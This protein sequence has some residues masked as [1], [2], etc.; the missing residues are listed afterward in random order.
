MQHWREGLNASEYFQNIQNIVLAADGVLWV[1]DSGIPYNLESVSRGPVSGGAKLISYNGTTRE[2]LSTY[3]LPDYPDLTIADD[4]RINTTTGFA[5]I[6][7]Q[8]EFGSII[9]VN[10]KNGHTVK[11]LFNSTQTRGDRRYVGSY[12]GEPI[13]CWKGTTKKFCNTGTNGMAL[14]NDQ[15]YWAPLASRRFYYIAQE[16]LNNFRL[17]NDEVLAAVQDPGELGSET[18][19]LAADDQGR[20]YLLATD[21]NAIYYVQTEQN[22]VE[23]EVNGVAPGGSGPVHPDNYWV[24]SLVR[25]GLIQHAD[26]AAVHQGYLYFTTNQLHYGLSRQYKNVDI[27]KGPFRSYRLYIGAGASEFKPV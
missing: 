27:R 12:N 21:A 22:R 13:Y 3:V 24:K 2:K 26:S 9:V 5:Y 19:G 8:S 20:L 18:A 25:S 4:V 15:L 16:V 17:S 1:I 7:D 14:L 6:G 11:R 10:L 23:H